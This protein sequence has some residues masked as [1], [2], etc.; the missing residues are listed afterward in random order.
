M[1]VQ[2]EMDRVA[3]FTGAHINSSILHG[4]QQ[5]FPIKVRGAGLTI[6]V[7]VFYP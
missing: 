5:R 6:I 3:T 7:F 4:S 2:A 1:E